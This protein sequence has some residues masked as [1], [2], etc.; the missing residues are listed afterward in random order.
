MV[1][2]W[3]N[4]ACS[5]YPECGKK[6]RIS[7]GIRKRTDR[8]RE[9]SR[10]SVTFCNANSDPKTYSKIDT[11][12]NPETYA[13]RVAGDTIDAGSNTNFSGADGR[14]SDTSATSDFTLD[15]DRNGKSDLNEYTNGNAPF[16]SN[17][18]SSADPQST[19]DADTDRKSDLD[20]HTNGNGPSHPKRRSR[21]QSNRDANP[22]GHGEPDS[23]QNKIDINRDSRCDAVVRASA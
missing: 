3:P 8:A 2:A 19:F 6:G 21:T 1:R 20:E 17:R 12:S 4:R 16:H 7:A 15:T 11:N 5:Y 13:H 22:N 9:T 14:N 10:V 18:H 23:A